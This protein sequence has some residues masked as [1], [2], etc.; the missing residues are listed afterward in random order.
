MYVLWKKK[1]ENDHV[2]RFDASDSAFSIR[3]SPQRQRCI[4]C[5]LTFFSPLRR[6]ARVLSEALRA[7]RAAGAN[8]LNA[9]EGV[10]LSGTG[11][12]TDPLAKVASQKLSRCG[13]YSLL[14]ANAV[15]DRVQEP[16]V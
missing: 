8:A 10:N 14:R 16:S 3:L 5:L 4:N 1:V 12:N 11:G 9:S 2:I 7:A 15:G 6:Q 13:T